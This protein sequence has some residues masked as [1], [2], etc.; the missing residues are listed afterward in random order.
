MNRNHIYR[1]GAIALVMVVLLAALGMI[2]GTITERSVRS[3]E[4]AADIARASAAAQTISGPLVIVP[5]RRT[6]VEWGEDSATRLRHSIERQVEGRFYFLPDDL[7][8]DGRLRTELRARG[9]YQVRLYHAST[10]LQG[11][12]VLPAQWGVAEDYAS[13]RFGEPL[14]ALGVSDIRGIET[15]LG[16]QVDGQTRAFVP[17]SG[18]TLLPGGVHT[19]LG[20][21]DARVAH[22]L[23]FSVQLP[24]AGTGEIH[25]TPLGR[26]TVVRLASDWPHPHFAD[27][28][29]PAK[30][31]IGAN[32]FTAEWRTT[33][34]AT[35]L[36][37][38]LQR[39]VAKSDCAEFTARRLGV[40][41][42]DPVSQYVK[43]ERA[44]K[45]AVLF[46]AL[47]FA[48][49]FLFE[50]LRRLPVHPVQYSMV[51][52]ALALFY[53]L[54]LSLAEHIGF[55]LAYLVS[56][57]GCVGLL[58]YYISHVL[59]S[60]RRGAGFGAAL[61]A[62]Y[63]LLYGLLQ[64]EDYA[65]LMGALLLFGVL[66]LVMVL[67]RHVDWSALGARESDHTRS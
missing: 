17:G 36:E 9:I 48:G 10:A 42:V 67:T 26:N 62:L 22:R 25:V 51:G 8:I 37:E 21:F 59:R 49:F 30:R 56:S 63:A 28:Y 20:A 57:I 41:F 60:P 5:W 24:L 46:M 18:T 65:L 66:A 6:V 45:Y 43:T 19:S 39:C 34:F 4:V 15:G 55:E 14:L 13:Y 40:S 29:L 12:F 38:A 32:G 50:V 61:A 53:L 52:A 3:A 7:Q 11:E 31:T 23:R 27:D 2:H 16:L 1:F 58:G 64:A 35:N 33:W 47:T 44:I 54:L